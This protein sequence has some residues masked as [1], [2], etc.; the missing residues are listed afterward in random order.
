MVLSLRSNPRPI[1]INI[2]WL[3][4]RASFAASFVIPVKLVLVHRIL[5]RQDVNRGGNDG[6]GRKVIFQQPC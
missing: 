3:L 1:R 6:K 2:S 4:K 5:P